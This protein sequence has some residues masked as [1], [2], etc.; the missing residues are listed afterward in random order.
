MSDLISKIKAINVQLISLH[1]ASAPAAAA[2]APAA[3]YRA[4]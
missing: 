2:A 4:D 3:E 1:Q